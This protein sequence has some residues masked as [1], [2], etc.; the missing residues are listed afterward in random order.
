M[1]M[2]RIEQIS[3]IFFL[4]VKISKNNLI[5][6][7]VCHWVSMPYHAEAVSKACHLAPDAG[8]PRKKDTGFQGIAGQ[9]HNDKYAP[10]DF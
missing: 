1:Q 2:T 10:K 4:Q 3:A 8:F 9:S 6:V 7:F 5:S